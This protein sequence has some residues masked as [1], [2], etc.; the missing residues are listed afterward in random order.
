MSQ[1]VEEHQTTTS[2]PQLDSK[3]TKRLKSLKLTPLSTCRTKSTLNSNLSGYQSKKE[4]KIV[5]VRNKR[6]FRVKKKPLNCYTASRKR[7]KR[8]FAF[9]RSNQNMASSVK[10]IPTTNM[11]LKNK[12]NI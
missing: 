10:K 2:N 9:S 12:F 3:T 11:S 5:V 4:V 1:V 6:K 8:V 7:I